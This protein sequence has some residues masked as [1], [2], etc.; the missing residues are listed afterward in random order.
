MQPVNGDESS[1]YGQ[2][3]NVEFEQ[4]SYSPSDGEDVEV[5]F[6]SSGRSSQ[7]EGS[8]GTLKHRETFGVPHEFD[9]MAGGSNGAK[10]SEE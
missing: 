10:N 7:H 6:E 1:P 4:N 5:Q 2:R 3:Q 9:G 8:H